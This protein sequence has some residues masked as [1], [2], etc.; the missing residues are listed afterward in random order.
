MTD[1]QHT[2]IVMKNSKAEWFICM[3]VAMTLFLLSWHY[4]YL[5]GKL[6]TLFSANRALGITG[7]VLI[8]VSLMQGAWYRLTGIGRQSIRLRRSLGI[9]GVMAVTA[10][11]VIS[12]LGIPKFTLDYYSEK[13]VSIAIGCI[14]TLLLL[15]IVLLSFPWAL[16]K[17]GAKQWK[18]M[19]WLGYAAVALTLLHIICIGKGPGM[20]KWVQKGLLTSLPNESVLPM[21]L[22]MV[23]LVVKCADMLRTKDRARS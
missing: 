10:H 15:G 4:L 5:R 13:S 19:Q 11:V 14:G 18:H 22:C 3:V 21:L 20:Y 16:K 9:I 23:T 2:P 12:L 17:L 7:T 6:Y 8:C 1:L